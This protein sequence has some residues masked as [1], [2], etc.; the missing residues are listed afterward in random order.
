MRM[1]TTQEAGAPGAAFEL[2]LPGADRGSAPD[3]LTPFSEAFRV[4]SAFWFCRLRFL[5]IFFLV[6]L[7][8]VGLSLP[9]LFPRFGFAPPGAWPLA[10]AALL[11]AGNAVFLAWTRRAAA[12]AQGAMRSLWAQI[13]FDLAVLTFVVHHVGSVETGVAHGY[14]FHIVLSC[15]FFP[16]RHSL[17]VTALAIGLYLACVGAELSGLLPPGGILLDGAVR[18]AHLAQPWVAAFGIAWTCAVWIVVWDLAATLTR[19]VQNR[20]EDL[21]ATNR[22]L[23][24]TQREKTAH[25]LRTTHELKAPFAA[26]HANVQL[27][28]KG[29]CGPITQE[30]R[31]VL[32]RIG[33]RARKLAAE[34]TQMLQ[35]ANLESKGDRPAEPVAVDLAECL[36]YSLGQ[37]QA[38]AHER[39]I[40]IEE[41]LDPAWTVGVADHLKMMFDNLLSN[42]INYSRRGGVVSVSCRRLA[43]GSAEVGIVDRG[44]GIAPEKLP[45]I[46]EEYYRTEEAVRHNRES[47]GLGLSIVRRVAVSHGAAV[48]VE[49]R[50][51]EGTRF[52]L[53]FPCPPSA[54]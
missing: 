25:M 46:F 29:L 19:L 31:E 44:I 20:N 43:D 13:V 32:E 9:G 3:P 8:A 34:I 1:T 23:V 33:A 2:P 37:Q 10:A 41:S 12:R 6:V 52:T 7:G 22:R 54:A 27:L 38:V 30:T 42:A 51:G 11:S 47:T 24:A 45:R 17:V 53:R 15:I 14:L 28:L 35:L 49:S 40:G 36:R 48:R 21:F 4:R 39:G 26:I 18:S 50:P 16:R 5:V